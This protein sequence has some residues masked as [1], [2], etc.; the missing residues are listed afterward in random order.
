MKKLALPLVFLVL[1]VGC[2][3][4]SSSTDPIQQYTSQIETFGQQW[5]KV[6]AQT[7]PLKDSSESLAEAVSRLQDIRSEVVAL[8]RP[9]RAQ[10]AHDLVITYLDQIIEIYD[11]YATAPQTGVAVSAVT[12]DLLFGRVEKTQTAWLEEFDK[13]K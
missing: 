5:D 12:V 7:D 6:L 1:L 3:N 10:V 9:E 2:G 8:E 13:L 4:A 11:Y